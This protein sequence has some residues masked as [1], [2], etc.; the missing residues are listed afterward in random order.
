LLRLVLGLALAALAGIALAQTR[1]PERNIIMADPCHTPTRVIETQG[2]I[3]TGTAVVLH[4]L[5]ASAGVMEPLG[6][7]L[8]EAGWRVYLLDLAGH[9]RS[10]AAFSYANAESCAEAA[11]QF[12]IRTGSIQPEKTMLVGHSLGGAIAI[13]LADRFPV[14]ATVA[15]SP[16]LLVA[17]H[18]LPANLLILT[19][20]FDFGTVKQT[21]RGTLAGGRGDAP[22]DF[23]HH[24]V[25]DWR[26]MAGDFHGSIVLDPRVW[27]LVRDW[28]AQAT[29]AGNSAAASPPGYGVSGPFAA[30]LAELGLLAGLALLVAPALTALSRVCG[31]TPAGRREAGLG[32][33]MAM[34]RWVLACFF[35]VCLLGL[36]HAADWIRPVRMQGG[37]WAGLA[38]LVT[39]VV[40]AAFAR[41]HLRER[42][43]ARPGRR[44]LLFAA[45]AGVA[46][47]GAFAFALQPELLDAAVGWS[48][49]WRSVVLVVLLWPYFWAE[50]EVLGSPGRRGR[51][52]L[53]LVLRGVVWLA[54]VFALAVFWRWGLL[55]FLLAAQ[56]GVLSIGQRL[57]ADALRRRGGGAP[58]A[59]LL[60]AILAAG[61]LALV[62][63]LT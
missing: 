12:L 26:E 20:Q 36:L 57:A 6:Q 56:F 46:I 33:R 19:A 40:L 10:V 42:L 60:D 25:A 32:W 1:L 28:G 5:S 48:R 4:G 2:R 37:D 50:E 44:E 14:A 17:P 49:V 30:I 9:G 38:A 31:L 59:A 27:R 22:G 23:L 16:A 51:F 21:A 39:G 41:E 8:A 54:Q 63:P 61:A 34:A 18:R 13:R 43:P 15:V 55:I 62:L 53:F 58:A 24:R 52:L 47:V 11:L 35:S 29:D 45:L 3:G 7:S